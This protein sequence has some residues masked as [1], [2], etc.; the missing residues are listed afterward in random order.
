MRLVLLFISCLLVL[1]PP[2]VMAGAED[3]PAAFITASRSGR[4]FFKMVPGSPAHGEAFE[5]LADGGLKELWKV[6]GW[7]ARQLYLADGGR[8][9]VR[10]EPEPPGRGVSKE[11]LAIAFYQDGELVREYHTADLV[12]QPD[13]VRH[14]RTSYAWLAP[15]WVTVTDSKQAN[16]TVRVERDPEAE[17]MLDAA[18]IFKLKTIDRMVYHF[19]A[20][21]GKLVKRTAP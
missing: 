2:L 11:D 12:K 9:L 17:P 16:G 8:T 10:V 18:G 6:T 1:L 20:S 13:A 21:T 19:E 3:S 4:C 14:G 5:V 7:Y 15:A